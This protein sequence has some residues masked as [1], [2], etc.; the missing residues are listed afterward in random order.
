MRNKAKD[1]PENCLHSIRRAGIVVITRYKKQSW[2]GF[3][4]DRKSGD[5]SDFGGAK[6]KKDIDIFETALRE[7]HEESLEVFGTLKRED[8]ENCWA[9]YDKKNLI[10]FVPLMTSPKKVIKNFKTK[11]NSDDEMSG[12][13]W[14]R[15]HALIDLLKTAT[16][17]R[18]IYS[19][20][21]E[22]MTN[23]WIC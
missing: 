20:V 23:E 12:I 7:F 22:V 15:Q 18:T 13:V 16:P 11:V 14:V 1:I 3:G 9:V 17:K 4:I 2:F 21:K 6:I 5:F 8:I 10:I 19:K